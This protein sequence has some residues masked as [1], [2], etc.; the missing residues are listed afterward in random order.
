[1]ERIEVRFCPICQTQEVQQIQSI[2]QVV[3]APGSKP[4]RKHVVSRRCLGCNT[5]TERTR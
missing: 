3:K 1:M 5:S 2:D 4:E